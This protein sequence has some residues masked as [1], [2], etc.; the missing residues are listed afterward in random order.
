M[1]KT[2]D[3]DWCTSFFLHTAEWCVQKKRSA[4]RLCGIKNKSVLIPEDWLAILEN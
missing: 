2:E 3:F 1:T 4:Q